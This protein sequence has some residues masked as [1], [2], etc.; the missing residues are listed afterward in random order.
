MTFID[1]EHP[2]SKQNVCSVAVLVFAVLAAG[3][4]SKSS[5][6]SGGPVPGKSYQYD[7]LEEMLGEAGIEVMLNAIAKD[8][9]NREHINEAL[10]ALYAN[11]NELVKEIVELKSVFETGQWADTQNKHVVKVLLF[12]QSSRVRRE[13]KIGGREE[14]TITLA[15]GGGLFGMDI[16]GRPYQSVLSNQI[17]IAKALASAKLKSKAGVSRGIWFGAGVWVQDAQYAANLAERLSEFDLSSLFLE[18]ESGA[19]YFGG[20][21]GS[22]TKVIRQTKGETSSVSASVITKDI[23]DFIP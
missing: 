20:V 1:Y 7:K 23:G 2:T 9:F 17:K 13:S 6:K 14:I 11:D 16:D 15:L 4:D 21:R 10:H 18:G 3:C 22:E 12:M 5:S 8:E 19:Y